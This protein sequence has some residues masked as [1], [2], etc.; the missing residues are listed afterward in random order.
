MAAAKFMDALA[1]MPGNDGNDSDAVGAY[2]QVLL[3]DADRLLGSGLMP[4]I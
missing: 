2:T 3:S 1:R 4:E